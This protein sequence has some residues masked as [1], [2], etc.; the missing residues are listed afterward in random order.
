MATS[1]RV[2]LAPF[3]DEIVRRQ[4]AGE[5]IMRGVAFRAHQAQHVVEARKHLGCVGG[6]GDEV[7]R[8][9]LFRALLV[10]GLLVTGDDHHGKRLDAGILGAADAREQAETVELRH[11][12]IGEHHDERRI[13]LDR[14]PRRFAVDLLAHAERALEYRGEGRADE[15]GIVDHQH[16]LLRQVGRRCHSG[17]HSSRSTTT[18]RVTRAL[19]KS[20][21]TAGSLL[22]GTVRAIS[23]RSGGF[24][25]LPS[26]RQTV[27]RT[28]FELSPELMPRRRAPRRMNGITVVLRVGL[29]ARPIEAMTPLSFIVLQIH[30]STSP[31]RLSTAPAQVDLSS[32]LTFSR[33]SV[34]R[35][36]ISLA[37]SFFS[38]SASLSLP[39][40]ATT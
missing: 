38:Q 4:R 39:V 12:Q 1:V 40:S 16:A 20:S 2:V 10:L 35:S 28:S 18:R 36:R 13:G 3:G 33:L 24:M 30:A 9:E 19:M 7:V 29:A 6:L 22:N 8:A 34:L 27:S 26:R 23:F 14:A 25:S 32:G 5:R 21:N 11:F 15:L 17:T 37:P 31:P